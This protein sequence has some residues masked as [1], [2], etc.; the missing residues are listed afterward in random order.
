[1]ILIFLLRYYDYETIS[2]E[3]PGMVSSWS[4][5]TRSYFIIRMKW[6]LTPAESLAR[7]EKHR[8]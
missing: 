6:L 5:D 3:K 4:R 8:E 1:M 2:E 7:R